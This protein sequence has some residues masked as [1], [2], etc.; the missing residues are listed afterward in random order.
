[1]A[2]RSRLTLTKSEVESDE[3]IVATMH[4]R[5]SEVAAAVLR[6]GGNAVDAAVAAG[7]AIGVVEP[8]N[9]G[10]GGIAQLV[11]RDGKTGYTAAI[12]GTST[13]PRSLDP[14]AYPLAGG[15]TAGMYGWPAVEGDANNTG[16]RAAAVPG[17]PGCLV[18][19]HRRFGLLPLDEV[20]AG[21]IELAEG[22]FDLDWYPALIIAAQQQRLWAY[23]GTRAAYYRPDGSCHAPALFTAAAD[24]FVQK[25][26]AASLRRIAAQGHDGF[27]RGPTA[28]RLAEAMRE[29]G[30]FLDEEEMAAY[31]VRVWEPGLIGSYRDCETIQ[32]PQNTGAPTALQALRVLEGFDLA[33]EGWGTARAVHLLAETFRRVFQDRFAYLADPVFAPVPLAGLV[34]PRYAE[35]RRADIDPERATPAVGPGDPWPFDVPAGV[36]LSGVRQGGGEGNTTH[37]VVADRD[38]TLVS[39]TSTL[40]GFFGSAVVVPGLGFP[41]N[42]GLTWFDPRPGTVNAIAPGKRILWAG[43]PTVLAREGRPFLA[44]GAPGARRIM[45]AVVQ[46]VSNI[47]DHGMGPQAAVSSPRVHCEGPDTVI[48]SRFGEETIA[49]LREMGHRLD[50]KVEDLGTSNFARPLAI[51]VDQATGRLRAGVHVYNPATAI[52]L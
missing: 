10:L 5:A 7:F 21:A 43:T 42:N 37:I 9:S 24:R 26:L 45:S 52:G 40:G 31:R 48:D 39:L 49:R 51:V 15:G 33:A 3:A 25:D 20:M 12:D 17:T 11:V 46:V 23:P 32:A 27:Y 18:E 38:R 6:R 1:M 16:Y 36:A 28:H 2:Q 44:V 13:L 19:A 41:L 4:P 34:C 47:V 22:G 30:G 14:A 50:V 8:F 35:R 29:N